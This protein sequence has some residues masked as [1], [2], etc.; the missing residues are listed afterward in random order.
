MK[1]EYCIKEIFGRPYID[2]TVLPKNLS[3]IY[4]DI[5]SR[6][7]DVFPES[8]SHTNDYVSEAWLNS[9]D[10][11]CTEVFPDLKFLFKSAATA[12]ELLGH[13]YKLFYFNSW[14]QVYSKKQALDPHFHYG[15]YH[16]HYMIKDTDTSTFYT[17]AKKVGDTKVGNKNRTVVP[18]KNY[19]GHFCMLPSDLIHWGQ[20]NPS[21][22]IRVCVGYN[23]STEKDI[24]RDFKLKNIGKKYN[25][26]LIPLKNV[27]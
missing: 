20:R 13:D 22:D 24:P 7:E 3:N 21:D 11:I 19:D 10:Y 12:L 9:R 25:D 14:L 5:L 1:E 4:E 18:L 16:G 2:G 15:S 27:L 6:M 26:V 23:V 8:I 17:N